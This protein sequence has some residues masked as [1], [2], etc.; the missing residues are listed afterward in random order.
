MLLWKCLWGFVA[1]NKEELLQANGINWVKLLD[2]W[3]MRCRSWLSTEAQQ[4]DPILESETKTVTHGLEVHSHSPEEVC[5]RYIPV[6]IRYTKII[7]TEA[8]CVYFNAPAI[9]YNC[10]RS[11]RNKRK[12]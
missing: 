4:A 2:S 6:N 1:T 11:Y 7:Q 9:S 8:V 10:T 12:T 5:T 3:G